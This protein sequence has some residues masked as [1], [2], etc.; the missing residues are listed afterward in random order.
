M[1]T[2]TLRVSHLYLQQAADSAFSTTGTSQS[3]FCYSNV[4]S[5]LSLSLSLYIYIYILSIRLFSLTIYRLKETRQ[6]TLP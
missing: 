5:T 3:P 2:Y 1:N 6:T 4:T